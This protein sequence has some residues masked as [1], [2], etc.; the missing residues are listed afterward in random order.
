MGVQT[1]TK[2]CPITMFGLC[3]KNRAA[4]CHVLVEVTA[5]ELRH[6]FLRE[7]SQF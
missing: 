5:V 3:W 6:M 7:D 2:Y 1:P 4:N